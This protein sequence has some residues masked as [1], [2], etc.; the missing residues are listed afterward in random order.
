MCHKL[1][2]FISLL[3]CLCLI[4]GML[5]FFALPTYA[6]TDGVAEEPEKTSIFR[7]LEPDEMYIGG[8]IGPRATYIRAGEVIFEGLKDDS[9]FKLI[10]EAGI[11]YISDND[12]SYSGDMLADA[13][14]A[15]QFAQDNDLMYFMPAYDV[16]QIDGQ[17]MASDSAIIAKLQEMYQYDSFGGFHL[18][19]E[20]TSDM[21]PFISRCLDK[22][23]QLEGQLGYTD[24]NVYLNLFAYFSPE[25]LSNGTDSSMTWPKYIRGLSDAGADYLSFDLYPIAGDAPNVTPT[26]FNYL[27]MINEVA[28]EVNKPWMGYAQVGGD[29]PAYGMDIRVAN[30]SEMRWDVNTMLAFGAKGI[31]YYLLVSPPYF[32]NAAKTEL[33]THS[34]INVYG[35][36]TVYWHYA[37]AINTQIKAM[38]HILMNS[39]HEG[40]IIE[41]KSPCEYQGDS[42]IYTYRGLKTVSGTALIGCFDYQGETAL[43]VVNNDFTADGEIVLGLDKA[44]D[45]QI[46]QEGKERTQ[47]A[48]EITL[49]IK[50]GD[51]AMVV[52]KGHHI[53]YDLNYQTG[54]A[55]PASTLISGN[56]YGFLPVPEDRPGFRFVGWYK[57]RSASGAAVAADDIVTQPHSLYAKWLYMQEPVMLRTNTD[58]GYV[59]KMLA[60]GYPFWEYATDKDNLQTDPANREIEVYWQSDKAESFQCRVKIES[61]LDEEGQPLAGSVRVLGKNQEYSVVD[62]LYTVTDEMGE[63]AATLQPGQWYTIEAKVKDLAALLILPVDTD[64]KAD[65]IMRFD[66]IAV[67]DEVNVPE[68]SKPDFGWLIW[69]VPIVVV[70]GALTGIILLKRKK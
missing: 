62:V 11:D 25:W 26:W 68:E 24:L 23:E 18:R 60:Q 30:E 15:L 19:D 56:T 2:Q 38:D 32:A 49:Q 64:R 1:L 45:C 66:S 53:S 31:N 36:K 20:P 55:A 50:A 40:V 28:L 57:E 27:A 46:I 44:Y 37:K 54:V 22:L 21:F 67:M 9:V 3:V 58:T 41:G 12:F 34:L 17:I 6:Q 70:A 43:L 51:C 47:N 65:I 61:A 59:S 5:P 10:K 33:N 14:K 69:A 42:R 13:R 29:T 35:E 7:G 8:F 63:N 39:T 48:K 4:G 52:L 16:M